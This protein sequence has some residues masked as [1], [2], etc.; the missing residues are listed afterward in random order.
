M[1][2]QSGVPIVPL[3]IRSSRFIRLRIW[4]DKKFPLPFSRITVTVGEP[5]AV[6]SWNFD[7]AGPHIVRA[8]NESRDER[9]ATPRAA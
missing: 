3:T 9:T 5:V 8:L 1:A 7:E 4:D 6:E 2:L